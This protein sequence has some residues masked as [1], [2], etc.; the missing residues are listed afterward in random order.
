M[1]N[2]NNLQEK[3]GDKAQELKQEFRDAKDRI[4][5]KAHDLKNEIKERK[6]EF[7]DKLKGSHN[8]AANGSA[9]GCNKS[10]GMQP[11]N[12]GEGQQQNQPHNAQHNAQHTDTEH[13]Q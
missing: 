10:N 13:K 4:G 6:D 8:S 1:N 7:V 12:S 9:C 2:T 11:G 5:D 3:L